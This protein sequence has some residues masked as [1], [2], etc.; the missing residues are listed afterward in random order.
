[1]GRRRRVLEFSKPATNMGGR[2]GRIEGGDF[3]PRFWEKKGL[4]FTVLQTSR[5]HAREERRRF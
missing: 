1:L 3:R 2:E 4:G 5:K